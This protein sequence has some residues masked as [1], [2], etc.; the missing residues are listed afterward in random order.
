MGITDLSRRALLTDKFQF[1]DAR[2]K[3]LRS[4]GFRDRLFMPREL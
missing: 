2:D 3:Q 4:I 1:E